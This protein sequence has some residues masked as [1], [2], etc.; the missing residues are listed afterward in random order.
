MTRIKFIHVDVTSFESQVVLL[1]E[2]LDFFPRNEVD[3][4]V[5]AAG[6]LHLP[7]Q[8]APEDPSALADLKKPTKDLAA[9]I[10]NVNLAGVYTGVMLV[11]RYGMGLHK[12]QEN[13]AKA[14]KS[15]ILI[16]SLAGYCGAEGSVVS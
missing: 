5:P 6:I 7:T 10:I 16:A 8:I 1:R 4:F 11:S 13:G 3:V 12:T 2:A 9:S 14:S 15:I